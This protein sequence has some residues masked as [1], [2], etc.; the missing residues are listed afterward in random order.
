MS[1]ELLQTLRAQ[2][3]L[4][5][6]WRDASRVE[7]VTGALLVQRTTWTNAARAVD[8][9]RDRALLSVEALA[10]ADANELARLVRPAG[11]Y[12]TKATRLKGLAEFIA[13][14]GGLDT[15]DALPTSVL[16]R[17]LLDQPGIGPET[18]DVILGYAFGRAVFVVDAYARRLFERLD[19]P[20]ADLSDTALK[21]R[22]ERTL[23]DAESLNELHALIIT[24]GKRYCRSKPRCDGCPLSSRCQFLALAAS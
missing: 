5:Q 22:V 24:H 13:S 14:R 20:Q 6:W 21:E 16:R 1:R 18:A 2:L 4:Q 8:A 3:G 17:Q 19:A 7:I 12:R 11:F 9:L 23:P 15:L 10:A